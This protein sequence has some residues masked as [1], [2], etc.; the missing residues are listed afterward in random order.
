MWSFLFIDMT[1]FYVSPLAFPTP[2]NLKRNAQGTKAEAEE[3][4]RRRWSGVEWKG[5]ES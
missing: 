3:A 1:R 4:R 2:P 5:R